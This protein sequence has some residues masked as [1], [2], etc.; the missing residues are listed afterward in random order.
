MATVSKQQYELLAKR[1]VSVKGCLES[2]MKKL[3]AS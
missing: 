2:V 1:Y 3:A